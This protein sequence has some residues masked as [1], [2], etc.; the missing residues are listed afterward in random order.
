VV[1]LS[2]YFL[3][4][5]ESKF[6]GLDQ[7]NQRLVEK[8]IN[9]VLFNTK[10]SILQYRPFNV[11]QPEDVMIVPSPPPPHPPPTHLGAER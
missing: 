6:M 5:G 9:N 1:L 4:V 10:M 3:Y 7:L 11:D 2:L 8:A